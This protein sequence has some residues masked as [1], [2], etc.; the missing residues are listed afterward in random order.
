MYTPVSLWPKPWPHPLLQLFDISVKSVLG[1][2]YPLGLST[3]SILLT[4]YSSS[5]HSLGALALVNKPLSIVR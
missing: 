3:Y 4:A 2:H 5:C 1:L